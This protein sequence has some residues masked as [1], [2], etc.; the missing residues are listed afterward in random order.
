[1]INLGKQLGRDVRAEITSMDT[2]LGYSIGNKNEV[3]EALNFLKGDKPAEDLKDVIYSSAS[4]MLVQAKIF[5]NETEAK[6][7]I[8]E[9]IK[10]GKALDKFTAASFVVPLEL[11]K[12]AAS[13]RAITSLMLSFALSATRLVWATFEWC[14]FSRLSQ[15]MLQ[16]M[17]CSEKSL[18]IA[19]IAWLGVKDGLSRCLY[20]NREASTSTMGRSLTII[21]CPFLFSNNL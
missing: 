15:V 10:S 17:R 21:F 8:D 9:T 18:A 4:T 19:S 11:R 14:L 5:K 20:P 6:T 1:M 12:D 7:A 16:S 2:P 3:L 13:I